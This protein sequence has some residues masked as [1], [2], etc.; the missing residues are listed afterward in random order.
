[1]ICR[2]LISSGGVNFYLGFLRKRIMPNSPPSREVA[3][4][5]NFPARLFWRKTVEEPTVHHAPGVKLTAS[6][7]KVG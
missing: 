1:M 6:V 7:K 4:R 5:V 2:D 3:T